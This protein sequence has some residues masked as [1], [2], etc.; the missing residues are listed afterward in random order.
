M[1]DGNFLK[2]AYE[3]K[4]SI[5]TCT[6]SIPSQTKKGNLFSKDLNLIFFRLTGTI[7]FPRSKSFSFSSPVFAPPQQQR[8]REQQDEGDLLFPFLAILFGFIGGSG[9]CWIF[10]KKGANLFAWSWNNSGE[11]GWVIGWTSYFLFLYNGVFDGRLRKETVF[12][13]DYEIFFYWRLFGPLAPAVNCPHKKERKSNKNRVGSAFR[14]KE[15]KNRILPSPSLPPKKY[16][17]AS[18][19]P[20]PV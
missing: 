14:V 5:L 7:S 17:L 19:T 4:N 13:R 3:P 11:W 10:E 20:F 18:S 12:Q 1:N 16:Y 15:S 9:G 6:I 8:P 2:T